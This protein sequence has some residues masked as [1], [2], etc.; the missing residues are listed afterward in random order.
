MGQLDPDDAR[1]PYRQVADAIRSGIQSGELAPGEQLPT[2]Q[3]LASEYGV[4]IG[5]VKSALGVLR[6]AGLIVSRQGKGS[7]VRTQAGPADKGQGWANE[8]EIEQLR[9]ALAEVNRRLGVLE[10]RGSD[11]SR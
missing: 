11:P 9:Q 2:L 1:P 10:N 3:A 6:D 8:H 7:Y 4:S 5:T